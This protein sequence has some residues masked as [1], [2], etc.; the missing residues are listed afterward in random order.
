VVDSIFET[1]EKD[2]GLFTIR[3]GDLAENSLLPSSGFVDHFPGY[4]YLRRYK[5]LANIDFKLQIEFKGRKWFKKQRFNDLE[6]KIDDMRK[7]RKDYY[8]KN[9]FSSDRRRGIHDAVLNLMQREDY[10]YRYGNLSKNKQEMRE[11]LYEH[12]R[13]YGERNENSE[14][15]VDKAYKCG[16]F[17]PQEKTFFYLKVNP[18]KYTAFIASLDTKMD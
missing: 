15:I 4:D 1:L 6:K 2:L 5:N 16:L 8:H 3:D 10:Y 17:R 18:E 11:Y 7:S 9:I 13:S 12:F 14:D